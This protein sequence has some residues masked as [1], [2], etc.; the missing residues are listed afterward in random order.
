M[1]SSSSVMERSGRVGTTE[2]SASVSCDS[3]QSDSRALTTLP[4]LDF[5]HLLQTCLKHRIPSLVLRKPT[6]RETLSKMEHVDMKITLGSGLTST[7]EQYTTTEDDSVNMPAGTV[8]A[9]KTF[10]STTDS[11]RSRQAVFECIAREIE[12]LAHPLLAGHPNIVQLCFIGWKKDE[13]FPGLA[14]EHAAHGSLDFLIR[15]AWASLGPPQIQQIREHLTLDILMGLHAIH[16]AGFVHGDLKPEN[17]LLMSHPDKN[18]QVIAKIVDFGG[19]SRLAGNDAGRPHHYTPLWCAPEVLNEDPDIDWVKAD[20]YSYGL[21]VA[22]IWVDVPG[23]GGFG[24]GRPNERTS[25]FLGSYIRPSMSKEEGKAMLWSIKSQSDETEF[26]SII[27]LLNGK[28]EDSVPDED[29][30]SQLADILGPALRVQFWLR[31]SAEELL[32]SVQTMTWHT[33][34][35]S[36]YVKHIFSQF[37]FSLLMSWQ[38]KLRRLR[39]RGA[40]NIWMSR[41]CV[42]SSWKQCPYSNLSGIAIF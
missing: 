30:R 17:V 22:S 12:V 3:I 35:D 16:E 28:L 19:S 32:L 20:V 10:R 25:C 39:P 15:D 33:G 34:R 27:Y 4:N 23:H 8:V 40:R 1:S 29:C 2:M 5:M 13:E 24:D 37:A 18:R 41:R 14:M 31:P 42:H 6:R 38:G 36:W 9:L 7:V 26:N 21:I 11:K